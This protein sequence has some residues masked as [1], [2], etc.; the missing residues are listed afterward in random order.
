MNPKTIVKFILIALGIYIFAYIP[1]DTFVINPAKKTIRYEV[2]DK[3]TG[4]YTEST[5]KYSSR[6]SDATFIRTR[7]ENG[8]YETLTIT[9]PF[10]SDTYVVGNTY[11]KHLG[12]EEVSF[13][14]FL[15]CVIDVAVVCVFLLLCFF[16]TLIWLCSDCSWIDVWN[17]PLNTF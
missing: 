17:N 9:D 8:S 14:A 1:L 11:T 4:P 10:I 16:I 7:D 6:T 3:R 15:I 2:V 13:F 5:G 12:I